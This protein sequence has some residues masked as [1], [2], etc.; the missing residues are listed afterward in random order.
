MVF[1][2]I[3]EA[4]DSP[5]LQGMLDQYRFTDGGIL[6]REVN[7]T[8]ESVSHQPWLQLN[9]K[10]DHRLSFIIHSL[11]MKDDHVYWHFDVG[12]KKRE[13]KLEGVVSRLLPFGV[14]NF[15]GYLSAPDAD[16][17]RKLAVEVINGRVVGVRSAEEIREQTMES[18]SVFTSMIDSIENTYG[19]KEQE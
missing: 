6:Y 8:Y 2:E 19:S 7:L 16:K 17:Y 1:K 10:E 5:V 11:E 9:C 13:V 15:R 3:K 12:M 4:M 14:R 18:M